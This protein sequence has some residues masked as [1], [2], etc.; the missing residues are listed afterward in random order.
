[1]HDNAFKHIDLVIFDL[2]GTLYED[3]DHFDHYAKRLS[4]ELPEQNR[5]NFFQDYDDMKKG[6]HAVSIGKAYD[7]VRDWVVETDPFTGQVSRVTD[8]EGGLVPTAQWKAVYPG[9]VSFDFDTLIAIGDGWWLPNA[10]ARHYGVS[11]PQPAYHET[12]EYMATDQFELTVIEGLRTGL[13]ALGQKK[14][15]VLLTNSTPDDVERL[16]SMLDLTD[17]FTDVVTSAGKPQHTKAQF[18]TIME[19]YDASAERTL[20]IGDNYLNEIIPAGAIGMKAIYIDLEEGAVQYGDRKIRSISE[21]I[22]E[23]HDTH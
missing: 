18:K 9:A 11:D 12:K 19:R 15:V 13:Q 20:S 6:N 16:L 8:W 17:V 21:L 7:V 4:E 2:D 1:M 3:T 5:A 22:Q 23:M 10:A 14:Q